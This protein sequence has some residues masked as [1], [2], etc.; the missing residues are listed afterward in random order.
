MTEGPEAEGSAADS[1]AVEG[2]AV[3][4]SVTSRYRV[5]GPT[6][7][8]RPDG[9]EVPV[10]GVRLRALLTA[11]AAAGGRA[12]PVGHLAAQVWTV[13]APADET[14]ALQALVGRLRRALGPG[15]V[16]SVPGGY[17]L[18]VR[19]EDVDLFR[20]ERLAA[21]GAAALRDGDPAAAVRLLDEALGLWRGPALGGLPGRDGDPLAVRAERRRTEARRDRLAAEVAL[22]RAENALPG[23]AELA[24]EQPL[25]ESLAALRLRALR[26]AGRPAEALAAYEEV[27]TR[28]AT[29]LGTDPGPELKALHAELLA[30]DAA[31]ERPRAA[32]PTPG[33]LRA[34]L[35]SFVGRA[36]DLAALTAA[37][38]ERRLVTLLGPG[39]VGKT[40][41]ALEAAEAVADA[42]PDGTWVA[43]LGPVRD[44]AGVPEA[45]LNALRARE[46]LR[47]GAE[48]PARDPVG[49]LVDH[50]A[51]RRLLIVLDNC[52]HL[53]GAAAALADTLL[54]D[55]PGVTVLA[56]SREPLG[57][58]GEAVHPVEPLPRDAALQLLAD[59]GASA[60]PG[61][62]TDDDPEACA[63][64]CRR[65]DGLPLAIEL[66]AARLRALTPRQIAGRLDDRFRLLDRGSRTAPPRRQT[67]RAVVDWS[68]DLLDETERAVLR[69]LS[70][71][72]GGCSLA[73][74]EEVCAE[75]DTLGRLTSL[76]DKSLVVAAPSQ[77][78]DV[79]RYRL[80]ETVADY[81]AERLAE[82]GERERTARRHLAAVRELVRT[83]D[84]E[85]RGPRQTAWL[86]TLDTEHDNI[87]AALRTAVDLGEEQEGLCLALS[88]SWFWQLRGHLGDA[89]T[90]P[91]AVAALG[92]DPFVPP[93]GHAVR[94][95]V[96]LPG[97]CTDTP[98]PWPEERV[99]EARRGVRLMMLAADGSQGAARPYLEAVAD[100]YRPGMPQNG[101]QPGAMW[102]FVRL[103]LGEFDGLGRTMDAYV[104]CSR[105]YG[106]DADL[107]F[108]LLMRARL[109]PDAE[110]DATEAL[111]RF[112][113]AGDSWGV[114]EALSARGEAHDR[115]GGYAEA[116]RDFERAMEGAERI[117]ARGQA[118]VFRARLAS[119]R[120]RIAPGPAERDRAERLLLEAAEDAARFGVE[121]VSTARLLLTQHY[122]R[123]G[124]VDLARRQLETAREELTPG[125]AEMFTGMLLGL[126]GWLDCLDGDHARARERLA[127]AVRSMESL[128]YLVAPHLVLT[129]F[130]T[131]AWAMAHQ[132][133]PRDGARLL[134]AY[135]RHADGPAGTGFR[136]LSADAEAEIRT[137]AEAE[138]RAVL[139]DRA[140]TRAHAE[141]SDLPLRAAA[142]LV[143]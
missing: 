127:A 74:A 35:T 52:E 106:D 31:P 88:M 65:L 5:L 14:A 103:M 58:P 51:R 36:D 110:G 114:A 39:G 25:D 105:E 50:C 30:P 82:A 61:F 67:L 77:A 49:H 53:V 143:R 129:Q 101:R 102:F 142:A 2:S 119:V 123:T 133:D 55:C 28:L 84:Q 4:G 131:A 26:S 76:V 94:P 121:A 118:A 37:V 136:Q 141:G 117:G 108:A 138:L 75:P 9:T 33:N 107:G 98:P 62:R 140:Y 85:L 59:R 21:D 40:R 73:Q 125:T 128:A 29:R 54:T 139:D 6:R 66:A 12:V 95:A 126:H 80:L 11:L 10:A 44:E 42:W 8:L 134:G 7:V 15:A 38:R 92:P 41:L 32:R 137:R 68:W 16:V 71:F 130:P 70:V 46:P 63:E 81:A 60:R 43:E 13:T 20:F 3:G 124:R 64:I 45:V 99:W 47:W 113:K 104:T 97:R 72:S 83:A 120:L 122:G 115:A 27:R 93:E 135:D 24:A 96:P 18:D 23:L 116:A 56:T 109:V 86:E 79:M 22:G 34:Q 112:E 19:P 111:E 57:V 90:W 69:K 1:L 100:A 91:S 17:R 89:R 87:R 78:G 48:N 132:G